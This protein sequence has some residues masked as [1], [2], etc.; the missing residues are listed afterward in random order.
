MM[1]RIKI[2]KTI[3][4]VHKEQTKKLND[5]LENLKVKTSQE[6]MNYYKK[7][8]CH[9]MTQNSKT[10]YL[11]IEKLTELSSTLLDNGTQ[12]QLDIIEDIIAFDLAYDNESEHLEQLKRENES[13]KLENE[14]YKHAYGGAIFMNGR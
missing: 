9:I 6:P 3:D 13:L 11:I 4:D 2:N 10:K 8:E 5:S 7:G 12:E 1:R 14:R